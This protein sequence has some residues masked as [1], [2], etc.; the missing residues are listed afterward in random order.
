MIWFLSIAAGYVLMCL[1]A[2]LLIRLRRIDFA[3]YFQTGKSFH[4]RHE[5][6]SMRVLSMEGAQVR[7]EVRMEPHS[8][9]PILHSHAF[10]DETFEVVQGTLHIA[11]GKE[12]ILLQERETITIPRNTPHRP[13]NPSHAV[14]VVRTS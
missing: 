13:F 7:L 14:V 2:K 3:T 12:N 6:L 10:F 9:G 5:G 4:S 1:A 11:R 8:K